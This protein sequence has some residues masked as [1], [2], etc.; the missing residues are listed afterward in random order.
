MKEVAIKLHNVSKYYKLYKEPKDR[1]KEALHPLKKKYHKPYYALK[2]VDLDVLQG[3]VLGI[4]GRNGSGKS[5]LLKLITGVLTPSEGTISTKGKITALLE[6]GAGFNPEFTGMDNVRFYAK[7][8]GMAD[9]EINSKLEKIIDFAELGDFLYQPVKTYSSGMKSRLGFAVAVHVDPE[10]LILDEVMA[11]G[12]AGF[13]AKCYRE[14]RKFFESGK[15]VIIVSHSY[16]NIVTLCN[17]AILLVDGKIVMQGKPKDVWSVHKK[18]MFNPK[19][20]LEQLLLESKN[21]SEQSRSAIK[22]EPVVKA[23]IHASSH[24]DE[25]GKFE[26]CKVLDVAENKI[27]E[28][29]H[30][31]GNTKYRFS[32][33]F[34]AYT[35]MVGAWFGFQ[36][37]TLTGVVIAGANQRDYLRQP[38]VPVAKGES[39]MLEVDI[40]CLLTTGKYVIS[41]FVLSENDRPV[42]VDEYAAIEVHSEEKIGGVVKLVENI[43]ILS[44][45]TSMGT[46]NAGE[47]GGA[48]SEAVHKQLHPNNFNYGLSNFLC[49][50]IDFNSVLEF[51]SGLGFLARSIVDNKKVD[52][53]HCIEPNE[54]KGVYGEE[55]KPRLFALDIFKEDHPVMLNRRYELVCSIEVAEHIPLE[56]HGYLFDFLVSKASKWVVFSG[57]RVGQG[58]HGHIAERD[59]EDWKSE[60]LKR[61]CIFSSELTE[62]IRSSCD[63]KNINH[64]KN[65]MVFSVPNP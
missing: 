38:G 43:K 25:H 39:Y 3:D 59:E 22:H 5:S 15:T 50:K 16:E 4:I 56:N 47:S 46:S 58:G 55:G 14:I 54:I 10:I 13:Q 62:K 23:K 53:Y 52:A 8:L 45:R 17:K 32:I 40:D 31:K 30:L 61:G 18:I 27:T 9:A 28:K 20:S 29:N 11:V 60:F 65:L 34:T 7:I 37:R 6:L 35:E 49:E 41:C 42:I 19:T 12:D 2:E 48:W 26:G 57:A 33:K 1:L 36:V 21:V 44:L 63:D 64:R 51:G 24:K